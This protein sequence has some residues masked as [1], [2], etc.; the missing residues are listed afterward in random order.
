LALKVDGMSGESADLARTLS[1][2]DAAVRAG[3]NA[4]AIHFAGE[5]ARL[6]AE[7]LPILVL[8]VHDSLNRNDGQMALRYASR[9]R[10]INRRDPE[11]LNAYGLALSQCNQD[12]DALAVFDTALRQFPTRATLHYNKGCVL[13]KLGLNNRARVCFE[14][15]VALQPDHASA[16]GRLANLA[17]E[18][19]DVCAARV[20]GEKTLKLVPGEPVAI[21]ALASADVQ[22]KRYDDAISRVRPLTRET[23]PSINRALALGYF[24]DALD[25]LG[26]YDDAFLAYTGSNNTLRE[27]YRASYE[28]PGVEQAHESV[29]RLTRYF[30]DAPTDAWRCRKTG[31]TEQTHVFLVG[32]PRSG[33]TLL[34]QV[35]AA[36]PDVESMDER[37]CLQDAE[38]DF[39]R[40]QNGLDKLAALSGT[41]LAPWREA[42]W[43]HVAEQDIAPS[44]P[45]FV[46]KLP[47]NAI[48]LCLIAKLFPDAKILFALRNPVDVVWSC[49]RRRFG[50]NTQMYEFLDLH[51]TARYYDAVMTLMDCYRAKLGLDIYETV[52][53]RTVGE[54]ETEIRKIC[55]FLNIEWNDGLNNFAAKSRERA[56]NTPSGVQVARGLYTNAVGQWMTYRKQLAPILPILKPWCERFGYSQ[57]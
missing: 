8:A 22:E 33:T 35:L 18:R 45:V 57:E 43:A 56:P 5:A 37:S 34:E 7:R 48:A 17:A 20:A 24:A 52:Y 47:F 4:R 51:G 26:R 36:H 54:F 46:D 49:Y 19:G 15:A 55:T 14:R 2:V 23:V 53:E 3:D 1:A 41:A 44:R 6:G 16:L 10:Q 38:N 28:G 9:A 32:F 21:L 27:R 30:K 13:D 42:Y 31:R 12:K 11:V 50:M 40:P 39:L 29:T 25:G